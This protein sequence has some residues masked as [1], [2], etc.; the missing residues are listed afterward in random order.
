MTRQGM[1][2]GTIPYMSPEQAEGRWVDASSD[3]FSLGI[4]LYEMATGSR[5]FSG[6]TGASLI[7]SI[8]RD[9]PPPV[10]EVRP[11]LPEPLGPIVQRCLEKRPADRYSSAL[12]VREAL[13]DLRRKMAAGSELDRPRGSLRGRLG[14]AALAL[15]GA[16]LVA[17][18]VWTWKGLDRPAGETTDTVEVPAVQRIRSLAVLPLENA[19]GRT[20]QEFFADGMTEALINDLSKI[21][22]LTVIARSSSMRYKRTAATVAEIASEL[23]VDAVV[24]GSVAREGDRVAIRVQ[25]IDPTSARIL[26]SKDD[27]RSVTSLLALQREFARAIAGGIEVTLTPWERASL[28]VDRSVDPAAHEAYLKGRFHW[29]RFTPEDM[30][31]ARSYFELALEKDPDYALAWVGLADA[32]STP[33][34]MGFEPPAGPFEEAKLAISRAL[35][36]DPDL[37][38]AHDLRAR[39]AFAWDWDWEAADQGFRRAIE[40]NPNL[41]DVYWVYSQFLAIVGRWD[42]VE[43]RVRR[44]VELDPLNPAIRQQLW[45]RISWLGRHDEAI[46][47]LDE[48]VTSIDPFPSEHLVADLSLTME[49]VE[50]A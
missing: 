39:L 42:E 25:L 13:T 50:E 9:T 28:T 29:Y 1:V 10:T 34:H 47:G 8:L 11:E 41:P 23:G 6:E 15:A 35:E 5:P 44:A 46:A 31:A 40:L 17:G 20:N 2:L 30:V 27:E 16:V 48:L 33:A 19:S 32:L 36:L 26:W 49:G 45:L 3:L 21:G 7:S 4:V 38:E 37:A 22:S 12:E 14:V 24:E 43:E 18:I